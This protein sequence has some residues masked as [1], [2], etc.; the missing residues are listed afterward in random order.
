MQRRPGKKAPTS[1][2]HSDIAGVCHRGGTIRCRLPERRDAL[3]LFLLACNLIY[4]LIVPHDTLAGGRSFER[5][6]RATA[7]GASTIIPDGG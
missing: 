2:Q 7:S 1:N 5:S 4:H 3:T 6:P